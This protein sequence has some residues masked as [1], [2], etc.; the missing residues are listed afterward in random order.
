[1]P[2]SNLI[3]LPELSYFLNKIKLLT[4]R[5]TASIPWAQVDSTSTSTAYTATVEGIT[6][7]RDGVCLMLMN[8]VVT[9]ESGFT[10]NINNL[11]AKPVYSTL[12]AA[13][14]ATT[15]FN[16]AYTFL[17]VYNSHRVE[18]GCWDVYYGYDSNT[19]TIAYQVRTNNTTMPVTDKFYRYRLLFTAADREH[20]VPANTSTSTN[21]TA[22][23]TV[24][25]RP[26]DPFGA[27]FYYGDTTA[28]N[29]NANPSTSYMWTQYNFTL[30]YSFNDTGTDLALTNH[31]PVYIKCAPQADGSAIIDANN[32][33]VQTLPSTEDGEIYIFLGIAS[34][35]TTVELFAEHPVFWYK[36]GAIRPWVNE[37]QPIT[38][39]VYI[40]EHTKTTAYK[41]LY[42]I[43]GTEEDT[44]ETL[45]ARIIDILIDN[46]DQEIILE[47]QNQSTNAVLGHLKLAEYCVSAGN[48]I[49][50]RITFKGY[51]FG[52]TE[53]VYHGTRMVNT[54][55]EAVTYLSVVYY[56]FSQP[57]VITYNTTTGGVYSSYGVYSNIPGSLPKNYRNQDQAT[58]IHIGGSKQAHIMIGETQRNNQVDNN[59]NME[60]QFGQLYT[61]SPASNGKDNTLNGHI[62]IPELGE[63]YKYTYFGPEHSEHPSKFYAEKMTLPEFIGPF[64]EDWVKTTVS[65]EIPTVPTN[66]SAFT[67]DAGYLT[68]HQDISGKA[69]TTDL[70]LIITGTCSFG[71]SLIN[72][73]DNILS[74]TNTSHTV[75]QI[76]TAV[77]ANR[78]IY[79]VLTNDSMK[80]MLQ[81]SA[82]DGSA[83]Y[84]TNA[85]DPF[86]Q[87][88]YDNE[89][90]NITIIAKNENSTDSFI[91][92]IT[93]N[94][95]VFAKKSEVT[96]EIAT[97]I[98]NITTFD[99]E[100][101]Q[102]LPQSGTEGTIYFVP[103]SHGT[104]D[105][106]D[107][108]MYISNAWEKIG[109]TA[110]DLS[111]YVQSNDLAY[112]A[113]SGDYENLNNKPT[114]PTK[115]SDLTND[116]N[117]IT[118]SDVPTEL[119]AVTSSDNGKVLTVSSGVWAKADV[120]TELPN[121]S[122]SDNGKILTVSGGT[123]SKGDLPEALPTVTSS[124]NGKF[125]TV[126]NGAWAKGDIPTELPTVTSSDNDKVLAVVNGAWAAKTISIP[127]ATVV[128]QTL[129]SGTKIGE[130]NGVSLYAPSYANADNIDY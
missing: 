64:M 83:Y 101:V 89:S 99:T 122:S 49:Y 61:R 84:F 21:A 111:G 33:Y 116:S 105:V 107:E 92:V 87:T 60:I 114:I 76:A 34:S 46:P 57:D 53:I 50:Y 7:L 85:Y 110:V 94:K 30:G 82:F 10:V 14:R 74:V 129:T 102:S 11:G 125:L 130:V 69:N 96:T 79:F 37:S 126:S 6:E 38:I 4:A 52:T 97:A 90:F 93:Y 80:I 55:T 67:N 20:Y 48:S 9:S 112:V 72:G 59:R 58:Q 68:S 29:A 128:T 109:S 18:G 56:E 41:A 104:N 47:L 44:E 117:F 88:A 43:D 118:L 45:A 91:Y 8:G 119:P 106:Y 62:F 39:P 27:I 22:S 42:A 100:V 121:V 98:G 2:L 12:A 25:Q 28:I 15:L 3:S 17:L 70:P 103:N 5:K 19:N 77:A 127:S 31:V 40:G 1:M 120:P 73:T 113:F 86:T 66:V 124:D 26:I 63:V 24:N 123:W 78:P 32:P 95:N 81:Y 54:S 71:L 13:S 23:R 51:R 16:V 35:A 65:S 115:V 75:Q 36:N 108:Y